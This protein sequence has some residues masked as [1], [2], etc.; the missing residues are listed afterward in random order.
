[1]WA[2][3]HHNSGL[4]FCALLHS[5]HPDLI[6]YDTLNQE[7]KAENLKLAFDVAEKLGIPRLLEPDDS[8]FIT[9][10]SKGKKNSCLMI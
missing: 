1:M 9:S 5:F 8:M 3:T 4:A 10:Y 7:D 6:P 2:L